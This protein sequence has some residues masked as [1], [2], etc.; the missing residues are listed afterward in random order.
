VESTLY[1]WLL[2][3]QIVF[4]GFALMATLELLN[5][6]K[7]IV[8]KIPLYFVNVNIAIFVAWIKYFCGIRQEIWTPSKRI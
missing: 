2:F 8:G 6:Q 5:L 3:F 4:Y 1:S 7:T